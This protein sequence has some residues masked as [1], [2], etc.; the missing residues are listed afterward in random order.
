MVGWAGPARP[1]GAR[2]DV[3][4]GRVRQYGSGQN[5]AQ[6]ARDPVRVTG[7]GRTPRSRRRGGLGTR[8]ARADPQV[9]QLR[10]PAAAAALRIGDVSELTCG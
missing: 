3:A 8:E 6:D 4:V 9:H 1:G 7:P 5:A 10:F 2:W